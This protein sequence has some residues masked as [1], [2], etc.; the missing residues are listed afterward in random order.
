[1]EN[2]T[3]HNL[4]RGKII[5]LSEKIIN[6]ETLCILIF[7]T[8]FTFILFLAFLLFLKFLELIYVMGSGVG[9]G[10]E[11]GTTGSFW[12]QSHKV[13]NVKFRDGLTW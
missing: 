1:M 3:I 2:L 10:S 5:V 13:D 11:G 8:H 6:N 7:T 9:E 4:T 12:S